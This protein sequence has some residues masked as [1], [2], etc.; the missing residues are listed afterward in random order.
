MEAFWQL[1]QNTKANWLYGSYQ[2]VTN[3]GN[4]VEVIR[5]AITGN[6]FALFV[7]GEAIPFQAS[8]LNNE[9]F[10][11]IGTFDP[12]PDIVGVEDRDVGRR[13]ALASCIWVWARFTAPIRRSIPTMRLPPRA[14]IGALSAPTCA[15][16]TF[17]MR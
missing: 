14:A 17:P 16:M 13:M 3:Q 11:A 8:L 4:V 5:P 6:V 7:A 9:L 10:H 2:T 1:Y 12:H 15:A